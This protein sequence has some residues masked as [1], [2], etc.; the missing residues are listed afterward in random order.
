MAI[1]N[2][3]RDY[4]FCGK[5]PTR[6]AGLCMCFCNGNDVDKVRSAHVVCG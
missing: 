2:N 6:G 5:K 4:D 1:G 3:F